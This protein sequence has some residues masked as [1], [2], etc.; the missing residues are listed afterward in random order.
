VESLEASD[1]VRYSRQLLLPDFSAQHQLRLKH[2]RVII[3][4]LGGLGN[5]VAQYLAAGG[6][7]RLTMVDHDSIELSNLPR[8]PLF[9]ES[10]IGK[11]KAQVARE[12]IMQLSVQCEAEAICERFNPSNGSDL[13][14]KHDLIIDCCD[15]PLTKRLIDATAY[16]LNIPVICGAVSRYDGQVIVLGGHATKRYGDL[17]PIAADSAANEN[18][19][20]LGVWGPSVAIIGSIMAQETI[21]MLAFG[22]SP[23]EGRLMQI[24]LQTYECSLFRIPSAHPSSTPVVSHFPEAITM[25]R[26][27]EANFLKAN[28]SELFVIELSEKTSTDDI[29]NASIH[30]LESLI[31]ASCEWKKER[32]ML[33]SCMHG[34]R[35]LQAALLLAA[36]GFKEIYCV[37]PDGLG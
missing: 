32:P 1:R 6:V 24:D 36:D 14:K 19:E 11:S 26:S 5:P 27:S 34:N 4:G 33:L 22:H 20:T 31:W 21:R 16:K 10:D 17:F 7:G 37:K 18:C 8:Q 2:A 29:K 28:K 30:T 12:R 15:E 23:L 13:C 9:L 25:L 3:I 35:S